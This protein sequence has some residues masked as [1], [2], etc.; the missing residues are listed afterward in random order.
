[1]NTFGYLE[2]FTKVFI[3]LEWFNTYMF[4]KSL[5]IFSQL[6]EKCIFTM[7]LQKEKKHMTLFFCKVVDDNSAVFFKQKRLE[8]NTVSR[9]K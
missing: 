7:F 5:I 6:E 4:E 9:K 1:M 8:R 3:N 2:H